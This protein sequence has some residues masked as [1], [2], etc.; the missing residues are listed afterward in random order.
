MKRSGC[1]EGFQ[2]ADWAGH[3]KRACTTPLPSSRYRILY[4]FESHAPPQPFSLLRLDGPPGTLKAWRCGASAT[5]TTNRHDRRNGNSQKKT[6]GVAAVVIVVVPIV[7]TVLVVVVAV[8]T[9]A[10]AAAA[11]GGGVVVV[12]AA[13]LPTMFA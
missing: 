2:L 4:D 12:V 7:V 10:A 1:G 11:G 3:S 8:V 5:T 13:P 6:L 9:A